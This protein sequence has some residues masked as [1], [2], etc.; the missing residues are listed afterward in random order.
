MTR[1][2][3]LERHFMRPGPEGAPRKIG[4]AMLKRIVSYFK[5]YRLRC[6]VILLCIAA[7]SSLSVLPPFC[8]KLIIDRAIPNADTRELGFLCCAIVGLALTA[9]L[10]GVLQQ[11]LAA[12]VGQSIIYDIRKGLYRRLQGMSLRFYTSTR[13]GEIVSRINNDVNAVQGVTTGTLV[14]IAS[15]VA[16]LAAT[17]IALFSMNWRLALIAVSIVPGFYLPSKIVGGI[18]RRL[19]VQ[20]QESQASLLVFLTERLHVGGSIL[21]HIFGQK[22]ADARGF[23]ERSARVRELS[24][25]QT[26]VGRWLFMI[27]SVFSAAGPALMYWFGGLQ[28]IR[29]E[30]KVGLIVAFAA[31]LGQLYRPLVQLTT[32]YVD[33]QAAFGVFERI[34]EYLDLPPDVEDKPV[35]TPLPRAAGRI[36]FDRVGFS[37]PPPLPVFAAAN[38]DPPETESKDRFALRDVSFEVLPGE[39]VALV[40][41]SGAGKTTLTYLVPRFYDPDQGRITLDGHDLRDLGQEELRRHL[42]IVTQETFLF[43]ASIRENLLYARPEATEAETVEACRAANIHDFIAALPEKYD[44]LVGERGFRLSGGEKQRLSIARALLKDPSILILDEA[45]SSLDATSEHLIQTALEK[46]LRNRTSLIIAHRLS[47]ILRSD[48]IVVLNAGRVVE[49]GSHSDLLAHHGLYASLFELQFGK[50][51]DLAGERNGGRRQFAGA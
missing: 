21:T 36:E 15:N 8:V 43:H 39:Q 3:G 11:T 23:D 20:S 40:G 50:V 29:G 22:E 37:Y 44:T 6:A 47:T 16:T 46:L 49:V 9:G 17:S 38:G 2:F 45:T 34:F 28:A 12:R 24:V 27:L 33:I 13:S 5:P 1:T 41:P 7:A 48:K 30:M 10:L 4:R 14:M 19:S 35:P 32:V 42:G 31:L 25:R 26:V 51:L 18:R